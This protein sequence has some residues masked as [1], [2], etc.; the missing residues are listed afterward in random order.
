M[1]LWRP[2]P[3][4]YRNHKLQIQHKFPTDSL[5]FISCLALKEKISLLAALTTN[6]QHGD[7]FEGL[8]IKYRG[9]VKCVL[10]VDCE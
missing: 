4:N 10:H 2:A 8:G 9:L 1:N 3:C 6:G 5:H 7:N